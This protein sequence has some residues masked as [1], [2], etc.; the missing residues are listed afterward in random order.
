MC[1][2]VQTPHLLSLPLPHTHLYPQ[3]GHFFV[4][5]PE[6]KIETR[7]YG[8]A[9]YG[10]EVQRLC[11]VLER[12]LA[13]KQWI[14]GGVYSLADMAIYPWFRQLQTGYPHK[15]GIK[16]AE[17]LNVAQYARLNEWAE[18]IAAREPV[19]RGLQVCGW[20]TPDKPKPWL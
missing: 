2:C 1:V 13:D 8:V 7:D 4:Y 14:V 11:D 15:S 5:A 9:R 3:F 6:D 17:F 16:A 12:H 18:R 10:M 20:A 19:K